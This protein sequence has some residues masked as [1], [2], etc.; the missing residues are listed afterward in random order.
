MI[1]NRKHNEQSY[2]NIIT[3]VKG[4]LINMTSSVCLF[5]FIHILPLS[6]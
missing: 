2:L 1:A 3:F 4:E 5:L 6:A